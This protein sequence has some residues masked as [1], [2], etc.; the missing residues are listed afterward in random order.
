[1]LLGMVMSDIGN[2]FFS[3]IAFHL[4]DIMGDH[5]YRLIIS[6]TNEDPDRQAGHID[7]ML[8]HGVDGLIVSPSGNAGMDKIKNSGVPVVVI[9]RKV[10]GN[11]FAFAGLDNVAAGHMLARE[12]GRRNYRKVG[13]VTPD[14]KIDLTLQ[15]RMDGLGSG[16][17]DAGC[18]LSWTVSIPPTAASQGI[19]YKAIVD[20]LSKVAEP[21]D[22]V[23]GLTN[24]CTLNII[25]ALE[26][27]DLVWGNSMGVVGIDDFTAASIVRPA[28]SVVGQPLKNIA[29]DAFSLLLKQINGDKRKLTKESVLVDPVWID[30]K[31][32]PVRD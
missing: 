2:P 29:E 1:M 32:L 20:K 9:D 19:A 6:N 30:R 21:P 31:S 22:A 23:I 11:G 4:D 26:E 3:E 5:G 25:S 10:N 12:L 16:L 15:E 13:V 27:L 24:V 17:K 28:I 14:S 8:A 7:G 18:S